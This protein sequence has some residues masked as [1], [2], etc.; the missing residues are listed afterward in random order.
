M[1]IFILYQKISNNVNFLS[2]VMNFLPTPCKSQKSAENYGQ[3]TTK[4]SIHCFGHAS[5]IL[6][7]I[8]FQ[9][10]QKSVTLIV[11]KIFAAP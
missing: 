7:P 8:Y 4:S 1:L 3:S 6:F 11:L 9:F 10:H 2:F 5:T